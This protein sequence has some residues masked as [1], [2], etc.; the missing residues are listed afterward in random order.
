MRNYALAALCAVS[1]LVTSV[2]ALAHHRHHRTYRHWNGAAPCRIAAR[3]GGPCGCYASTL[4]FG[5]S[6]RGLWLAWNWAVKF[7]HTSPHEG[8]AAVRRHHVVIM[9]K[10][11]L[12]NHRF[13][14]RDSWG[15]HWRS[16]SG[17]I[18]VDPIGPRFAADRRMRAARASWYG[19]RQRVAS[20]GWLSKT[21]L[22]VA[23]RS[24]P[25]GTKVRFQYRGRT[26]DATVNDRGP[27][28]AGRS[29]DFGPAVARRLKF[30]GV[31]SVNYEILR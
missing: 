12:A 9:G 29:W 8:A 10:V 13:L 11:D 24:L 4:I 16:L 23:H 6:I 15:T 1:I 14:A 17:W 22:T 20:G 26:V 30:S 18:F 27:Y 7:P 5:R 19:R 2:P 28:I 3:M 25:F 31:H 21:R